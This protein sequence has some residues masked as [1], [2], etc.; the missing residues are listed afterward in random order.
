MSIQHCRSFSA[1]GRSDHSPPHPAA[2]NNELKWGDMWQRY[3]TCAEFADQAAYF[4]LAVAAAK[5]FDTDVSA[6]VGLCWVSLSPG[7][8]LPGH[9]AGQIACFGLW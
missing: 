2:G 9:T 1:H 3:G 6:A 8:T 5:K 7:G 4:A